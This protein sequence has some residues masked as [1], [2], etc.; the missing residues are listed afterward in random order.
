MKIDSSRKRNQKR[1]AICALG[2]RS[3]PGSANNQ[4]RRGIRK[5]RTLRRWKI[6]E[7]QKRI[8]HCPNACPTI[9]GSAKLTSSFSRRSAYAS[10]Y[11]NNNGR[12]RRKR[13][14]RMKKEADLNEDITLAVA[15][16]PDCGVMTNQADYFYF[17]T[18]RRPRL[19]II[20]TDRRTFAH[21]WVASTNWLR[22]ALCQTLLASLS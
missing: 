17:P 8:D 21:R 3:V 11:N 2:P 1:A 4:Q 6:A 12:N 15:A 18:K 13:E 5:L 7:E 16:V 9:P 10:R 20:A 19:A 14:G 22:S